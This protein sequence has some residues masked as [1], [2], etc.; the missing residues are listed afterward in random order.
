MRSGTSAAAPSNQTLSYDKFSTGWQIISC[1]GNSSR[2]RIKTKNKTLKDIPLFLSYFKTISCFFSYT[3]IY[4][5]KNNFLLSFTTVS[6]DRNGRA[7]GPIR[8]RH[9]RG[10][11]DRDTINKI[12]SGGRGKN[13][14]AS[15]WLY[16]FCSVESPDRRA[17]KFCN[18]SLLGICA[19]QQ[20]TVQRAQE[21]RGRELVSGK[22]RV[23]VVVIV[24]KVVVVKARGRGW[25]WC[26]PVTAC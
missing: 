22:G 3:R 17:F 8:N 13:S 19:W 2:C 14:V 16:F 26:C 20:R 15:S 11:T 1:A 23:I 18:S 24:V 10:H 25:V 6:C 4:L 5:K 21:K 9:V 12:S 7:P